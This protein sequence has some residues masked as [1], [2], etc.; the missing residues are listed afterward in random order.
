MSTMTPATSYAPHPGV[1]RV[2]RYGG[3]LAGVVAIYFVPSFLHGLQLRLATLAAIWFIAVL[4]LQVLMGQAGLIS[5]GQAAFVGVGA[6]TCGLLATKMDL[7]YWITIPAAG[8]AGV[9]LS[10]VVGIP[11]LKLRGHYLAIASIG[12]GQIVLLLMVN[13]TK[14]T[15]G[16]DGVSGISRPVASPEGYF[17]FCMAIGLAIGA[18]LYFLRRTPV[19]L[20][21][22]ALRTDETAA[23]AMGISVAAHN[24]I[25]FMICGF[26]A[27]V[28]GALIAFNEG[29]ISPYGFDLG[30]SILFLTMIIIG[31]LRYISGALLGAALLVFLA[32]NLEFLGDYY[33]VVYGLAVML[34]ILFA[35]DGAAGA[36]LKIRDFFI[37]ILSLVVRKVSA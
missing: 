27:G 9:L 18:A 28:S 34:V 11:T 12:V 31:G 3:F 33:M 16:M 32:P 7:D 23:G 17:Y 29:F 19:G 26:C 13:W 37:R 36:V 1:L 30:H 5:I 25:A 10:L 15:N 8:L 6:Y 14:V 2:F 35:P 20:A 24:L 21:F 22:T 4:G